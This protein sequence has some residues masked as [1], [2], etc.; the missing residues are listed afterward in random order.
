MAK[1]KK[2]DLTEL[3]IDE[4]Q[5]RLAEEQARLGSIKFNNVITPV[6]D[7]NVFKRVRKDIARMKTELRV[8]EIK[9]GEA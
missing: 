1:K 8:R 6:E 4:L 2:V 7:F 9:G 3:S 5:D